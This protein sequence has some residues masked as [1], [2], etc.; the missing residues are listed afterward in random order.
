[1][2]CRGGT[3]LA[4]TAG[5]RS[6]GCMQALLSAPSPACLSGCL[7][8]PVS[9]RYRTFC[10]SYWAARLPAVTVIGRCSKRVGGGAALDQQQAARRSAMTAG[11]STVKRLEQLKIPS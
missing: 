10:S 1:V 8:D 5:G 4:A 7:Y 3:A 9:C 2:S 11:W 6:R